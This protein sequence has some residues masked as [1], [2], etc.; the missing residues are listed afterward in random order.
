MEY[1]I[2]RG[3]SV[4]ITTPD[5]YFKKADRAWWKLQEDKAQLVKDQR[6]AQELYYA[7]TSGINKADYL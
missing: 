6:K 2:L 4:P 3:L 1:K 5:D 7:M